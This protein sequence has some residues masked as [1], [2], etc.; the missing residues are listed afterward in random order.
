M[1][2][3]LRSH[4]FE[5][6]FAFDFQKT[7]LFQNLTKLFECI[8]VHKSLK[9]AAEEQVNGLPTGNLINYNKIKKI[10]LLFVYRP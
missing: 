3:S 9:F 1:M 5:D 10:L 8:D 2:L 4:V 6:I 7:M